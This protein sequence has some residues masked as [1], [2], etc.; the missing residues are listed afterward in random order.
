MP[1]EVTQA[2]N[3]VSILNNSLNNENLKMDEVSSVEVDSKIDTLVGEDDG[4]KGFFLSNGWVAIVLAFLLVVLVVAV[5][6]K[7]SAE[8]TKPIVVDSDNEQFYNFERELSVL[9][10]N[11]VELQRQLDSAHGYSKELE[12]DI[13]EL[14]EINKA[15]DASIDDLR[16]KLAAAEDAKIQALKK[17]D[18]LEEELAKIEVIVPP[19][20]IPQSEVAQSD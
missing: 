5:G 15:K 13:D 3:R 12:L 16:N 17:I 8:E 2:I 18:E 7:M 20:E 19:V 10:S 1:D 9:K 11:N 4:D 6:F 14:K